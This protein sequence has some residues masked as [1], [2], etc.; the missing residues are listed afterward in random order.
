MGEES[1]TG[2]SRDGAKNPA[3]QLPSVQG[4]ETSREERSSGSVSWGDLEKAR[5]ADSALGQAGKNLGNL[6]AK[7]CRE[8]KTQ[9]RPDRRRASR[10][11]SSFAFSSGNSGRPR[12]PNP[13]ED[14]LLGES[15][16]G[17]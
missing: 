15:T 1:D 2:E 16:S 13:I 10:R 3:G 6:R 12:R 7:H 8:R 4:T 14:V 5:G 9:T 17:V 11:N